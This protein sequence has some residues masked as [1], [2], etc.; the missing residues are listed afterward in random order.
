[1]ILII[2]DYALLVFKTM[3]GLSIPLGEVIHKSCK[4]TINKSDRNGLKLHY[5]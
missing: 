3:V 4:Q 5:S 2:M 1:M